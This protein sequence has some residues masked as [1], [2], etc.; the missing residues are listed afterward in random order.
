MPSS[1]TAITHHASSLRVGASARRDFGARG[2]RGIVSVFMGSATRQMARVPVRRGTEG[3]SA[4]NRVPLD[5]MDR[6]AGTGEE[7]KHWRGN[8]RVHWISS[9]ILTE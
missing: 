6:T 4:G 5:S 2:A 9:I 1:V 7:P 8:I 3:S